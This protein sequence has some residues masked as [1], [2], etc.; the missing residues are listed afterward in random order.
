MKKYENEIA[1]AL[2]RIADTYLDL[3]EDLKKHGFLPEDY[4]PES[5]KEEMI[6][7]ALLDLK[8]DV[9]LIR[10]IYEED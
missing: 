3:V 5:E 8:D 9:D 4:I 10:A 6:L 2:K 1:K 7:R